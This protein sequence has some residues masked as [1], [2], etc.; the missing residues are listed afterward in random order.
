MYACYIKDENQHKHQAP[1]CRFAG[2]IDGFVREF[3]SVHREIT[4]ERRVELREEQIPEH[5]RSIIFETIQEAFLNIARHSRSRHVMLS[6]KMRENLIELSVQD[7]GIG[8][9]PGALQRRG[10]PKSGLGL[11]GIQERVESSN[12]IF[13]IKSRPGEGAT[14]VASWDV[15]KLS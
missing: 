12:G 2:D 13:A 1:S 15:R 9:A 8:F 10:I 14:V 3:E 4:I 6:L 5:L 11:S 7:D